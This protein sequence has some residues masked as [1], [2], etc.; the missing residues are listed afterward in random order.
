MFS[1]IC[2]DEIVRKIRS[3]VAHFVGKRADIAKKSVILHRAIGS[4]ACS[5]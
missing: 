2:A 3:V 4:L 5:D 1:M